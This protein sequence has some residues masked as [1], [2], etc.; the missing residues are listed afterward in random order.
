MSFETLGLGPNLLRSIGEVGYTEP[1]PIQEAAI[2]LIIEGN[3]VIGIAQTGTGK[4]AA[5]TLPMLETL[6]RLTSDSSRRGKTRALVLSPTRELVVQIHDNVSAYARHLSLKVANV[7]GGVNEAPQK[8]ALREGVDLVIATPGRLMDLMG[9]GCADFSGLEYFV[10]DEADRML[11]MG[12]L[13]NI[14]KIVRDLPKKGRQTLLFSATLSRDIEKLT[15]EFLH[16]PKT[17]EIGK[18]TNP[19]DTVRQCIHEVPKSAKL[20]LLKH[21]LHDNDLYSVLVF[22]R[23]KHGADRVARQ[24]S[25]AKIP[26]AAIHSNRSQNQRAR[27]LQDF[28]DGKTRVLVATDIAARGIDVEG[29]THVIN[30]DFPPHAEDY[31]HRIGRTGRANSAGEAISF[32]TPEDQGPLRLLERKIRKTIYRKKV[33]GFNLSK[34]TDSPRGSNPRKNKSGSGSSFRPK[35]SSGEGNKRGGNLRRRTGQRRPSSR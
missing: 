30:F 21:L 33:S 3:D 17:V 10:L 1:T 16:R 9:Q 26:T 8:K 13:P 15:Q 35:N 34:V 23:T 7:Y 29:I 18:R 24:L 28:K 11:D 12:F 22:T 19:A 14:R 32:I 6:E 5:F 20:S 2:P 27:A 25:K 4:T 31:V